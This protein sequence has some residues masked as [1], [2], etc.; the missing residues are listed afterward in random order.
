MSLSRI[1]T[2]DVLKYLVEVLRMGSDPRIGEYGYEVYLPKLVSGYIERLAISGD[3]G[4]YFGDRVSATRVV[5]H[6]GGLF[7]DAAWELCGMGVLRPGVRGPREQSTEQGNSGGGYCIT[8]FG[9]AWLAESRREAF[10]PLDP[11]QY[12]ESLRPYHQRLG[13]GFSCF[14]EEAIR[15]YNA[16][17]YLASCAMSGAAAEAILLAIAIEKDGDADNVRMIYTAQNGRMHLRAMISA[18]APE[19]LR[20]EIRNYLKLL[21]YLQ[22]ESAGASASA[23]QQADASN[24]LAQVAD[25]ARC[26]D[27]HWAVLTFRSRAYAAR[28]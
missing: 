1:T 13:A 23:V 22:S 10:L 8:S 15:C 25:F 14:A 16:R 20:E 4:D 21:N 12:A 9:R 18:D 2:E 3:Y 6:V 11:A 24:A 5:H 7:Y 26:A 19:L 17:A 28:K 27:T